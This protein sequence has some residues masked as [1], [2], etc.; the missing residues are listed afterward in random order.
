MQHKS[1]LCSNA[2]KVDEA[3][4]ATN[5]RVSVTLRPKTAAIL[6]RLSEVTGN[7]ISSIIADLLEDSEPVYERAVKTLEAARWAMDEARK[8][9]VKG[10]MRDQN[11]I[12]EKILGVFGPAQG[13]E[14]DER[15]LD[16]LEDAGEIRRRGRRA[17]HPPYLTGGSGFAKEGGTTTNQNPAKPRPARKG[18]K[19]G[20][21]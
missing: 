20:A 5:P 6:R 3:M 15:Q 7:S 19:N 17:S 4:T 21:V 12:H 14:V 8:E 1:T 16:L 13:G 9:A 18:G 11:E 10:Q 2:T